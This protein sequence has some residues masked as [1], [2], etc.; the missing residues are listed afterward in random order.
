MRY[1]SLFV[2]VVVAAAADAFIPAFYGKFT[3]VRTF[4]FVCLLRLKFKVVPKINV[5]AIKL[6]AIFAPKLF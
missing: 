2:I 6:V 5:I 1:S 3:V 4:G